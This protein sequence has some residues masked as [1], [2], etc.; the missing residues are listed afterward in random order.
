MPPKLALAAVELKARSLVPKTQ[1]SRALDDKWSY[2]IHFRLRDESS[3]LPAFY[4]SPSKWTQPNQTQ[5]DWSEVKWSAWIR[6]IGVIISPYSHS[7]PRHW[8]YTCSRHVIQIGDVAAQLLVGFSSFWCFLFLLFLLLVCLFSALY[9]AIEQYVGA[10]NN[11][12]R[13]AESKN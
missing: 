4:S 2:I 7:R 5:F 3:S 11:I 10:L 1:S 13:A 8:V 6:T 9:I 12:Q